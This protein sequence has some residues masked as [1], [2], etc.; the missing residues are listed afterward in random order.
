MRTILFIALLLIN[1]AGASETLTPVFVENRHDYWVFDR[2]VPPDYPRAALRG[3]V[4]GFVRVLHTVNAKGRVEDIEV[5]ESVPSEIF[6]RPTLRALKRFRF[7]PAESNPERIP[8]RSE[9]TMHFD[10]GN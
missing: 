6:I 7:K 10:L 1:P 2:T 9:F 8:V 3:K 5:I 4:T